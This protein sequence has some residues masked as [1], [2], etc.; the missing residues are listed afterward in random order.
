MTHWYYVPMIGSILECFKIVPATLWHLRRR[1]S[2]H[3]VRRIWAKTLVSIS[4]LTF[5]LEGYGSGWEFVEQAVLHSWGTLSFASMFMVSI[6]PQTAISNSPALVH[7]HWQ[8][9]VS[10]QEL[11][12]RFD[13]LKS[14]R[15]QTIPNSAM[16]K[17]LAIRKTSNF[18]IWNID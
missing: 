18:N 3:I 12:I 10:I 1:R 7:G 5:G 14:S 8:E 6:L 11:E 2:L 16:F 17:T 4:I 15:V 9:A 13:Q